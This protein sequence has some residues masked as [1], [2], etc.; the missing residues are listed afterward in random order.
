MANMWDN[1][2]SLL[3]NR[4]GEMLAQGIQGGQNAF[5]Q[6]M[7][8]Y[9]ANKQMSALATAKFE[10]ALQA[11]PDILQV[12]QSPG[13]PKDVASAFKKLQS[14][15]A[16]GMKEAAI[17]GAFAESFTSQK[18]KAQELQAN[19]FILQQQQAQ[20]E[21]RQR[22]LQFGRKLD[23]Y[24]SG[25]GHGVLKP[26]VQDNPFF[27]TAARVRAATGQ[28]PTAGDMMQYG[29]QRGGAQP[30]VFGSM[31]ELQ[32]RYPSDQFDY[33]I[34]PSP[35]GS[36]VIPDGKISPR[37]PMQPRNTPMLAGN[38]IVTVGPDGQVVNRTPVAPAGY[39]RNPDGS[40]K[41]IAGSEAAREAAKAIAAEKA[42]V[43]GDVER[44]NV[45]LNSLKEVLP[46]VSGAT[47]GV[48]SVLAMLPGTEAK[49]LAARLDTIKANIGFQQLAQMRAASPTGGA[50]G[51]IAVKELDFLQA[52]LGNLDTS[53]SP[54]Q[55]RK[56]IKDIQGS[57]KRW[58]SIVEGEEVVEAEVA[59]VEDILKKYE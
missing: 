32:K 48:G 30:L 41:P 59:T 4:S 1:S 31:D 21:E 39:E 10:G 43:L 3:Q 54:A 34:T 24:N 2:N 8:Q 25:V 5:M 42:K 12:L 26:Q 47:A 51:Q 57:I 14:G 44:A 11:N 28:T 52:S 27:K 19:R 33:N 6:G 18:Q 56:T 40:V 20:A 16:V 55:L 23:Q 36:V 7:L 50:L 38:E 46:K 49:D 45:V 35:D 53:Q 9:Q 13:A 58:K 15:G 22:L 29:M 17:L 37:A